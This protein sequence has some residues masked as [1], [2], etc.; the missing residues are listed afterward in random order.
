MLWL[1]MGCVLNKDVLDAST[2]ELIQSHQPDILVDKSDEKLYLIQDGDLMKTDTGY[3]SWDVSFGIHPIGDKEA[4]GDKKTPEGLYTYTDYAKSSSVYGSLLIHYP[5]ISDAQR[6]LDAERINKETFAQVQ[7][8]IQKGQAP[9]MK[10]PLGGYIL[11]H[12][13]LKSETRFETSQR[14]RYTDGCVGMSNDDIDS[15]RLSL[16]DMGALKKGTIL[17]VP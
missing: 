12:G 2:R 9:P 15:L 1:W 8:S 11:V 6:G 13:L 3:L 7:R 10:T 16:K 17:I 4:E 14:Y 5:D